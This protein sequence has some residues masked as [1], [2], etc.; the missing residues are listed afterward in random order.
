MKSENHS[1]SITNSQDSTSATYVV[2]YITTSSD[3]DRPCIVAYALP[4]TQNAYEVSCSVKTFMTVL[5]ELNGVL[6]RIV[7]H[8]S[9]FANKKNLQNLMIL[10]A[11]KV[12]QESAMGY[13]NR[14]DHYEGEE[15]A[16]IC[17]DDEYQLYEE[18]SSC[19]LLKVR[20]ARWSN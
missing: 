4:A 15:V 14:N 7:L 6:E 9:H 1:S 2:T 12:K 10:T 8:N 5:A 18:V 17:V 19:N 20:E 13:I 3:T 11:A 16:K